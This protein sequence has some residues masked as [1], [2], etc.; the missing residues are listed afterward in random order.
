M[1][2]GLKFCTELT[3]LFGSHTELTRFLEMQSMY[4][5]HLIAT[6]VDVLS[7]RQPVLPP[8]V[9]QLLGNIKH[10]VTHCISPL[11]ALQNGLHLKLD[12]DTPI[13]AKSEDL[14]SYLL[15]RATIAAATLQ[16][17]T[18]RYSTCHRS[19]R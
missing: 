6:L 1:H 3:G 8:L 9:E 19:N 4:V 11:A 10:M 2:M 12:D 16:V 15:T 5:P 13:A 14:V 7:G 17:T 18:D